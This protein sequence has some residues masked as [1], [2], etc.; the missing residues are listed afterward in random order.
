M[1][2]KQVLI[3]DDDTSI[4]T[5]IQFSLRMVAGWDVVTASS[6]SEGIQLAQSMQPDV[7]LLDVMMPKMDG[8]AT[9]KA[10]QTYSTTE[11]IPV[12]LLTGRVQSAETQEFKDMGISGVIAKPFNALDLPEQIAKILHWTP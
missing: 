2:T 11:R 5:I 7:I 10:L 9:F 4:Q 6:G 8:I 3:I 1:T 12:I